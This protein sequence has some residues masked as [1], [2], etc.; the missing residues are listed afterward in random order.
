MNTTTKSGQNTQSIKK[1]KYM[2]VLEDD[3]SEGFGS[4]TIYSTRYLL[5]VMELNIRVIIAYRAAKTY[6]LRAGGRV[7]G[8]GEAGQDGDNSH[9]QAKWFGH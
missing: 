9:L 2:E 4:W 7:Q 3:Y 8:E 1:C 5:Q 6:A